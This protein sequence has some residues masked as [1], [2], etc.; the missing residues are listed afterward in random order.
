MRF[1]FR[2]HP[3]ARTAVAGFVVY[4]LDDTGVLRG[5]AAYAADAVRDVPTTTFPAAGPGPAVDACRGRRHPG[6]HGRRR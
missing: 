1:R 2:T 4:R 6:N 5:L 3:F